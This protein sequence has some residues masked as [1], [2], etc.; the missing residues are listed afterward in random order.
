MS[1]SSSSEAIL[2]FLSEEFTRKFEVAD[3][4]DQLTKI[5]EDYAR[6]YEGS[7]SY[8]LDMKRVSRRF[9]M[10]PAQ[11]KGTLNC[12]LSELKKTQNQVVANEEQP[13]SN[14]P[15]LVAEYEHQ[16]ESAWERECER[17]EM[18]IPFENFVETVIPFDDFVK[19]QKAISNGTYTIVLNADEYVTLRIKE[20]TFG[21]FPKGTRVIQY[22]WGSDNESSFKGFAFLTPDNKVKVWNSFKNAAKLIK[23]ANILADSNDPGFYGLEYALR[24]GRCWRCGRTLTVPTSI[25]RGLGPDCAKAA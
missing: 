24:S 13:F 12:M 19:E 10:S 9:G 5:A 16:T 3:V 22:L 21:D 1:I 25:H 6:D 4:T 7:F 23:A 8:M 11:A 18:L 17:L 14:Q 15:D 2:F 20:C